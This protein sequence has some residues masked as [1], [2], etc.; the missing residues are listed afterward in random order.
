M[1][2]P[3][4]PTRRRREKAL[5][6]MDALAPFLSNHFHSKI[7]QLCVVNAVKNMPLPT[8]PPL[9]ASSWSQ[10]DFPA[11]AVVPFSTFG[12][13]SDGG[14]S[15]SN[16]SI[17]W[18]GLTLSRNKGFSSITGLDLARSWRFFGAKPF[19]KNS[20]LLPFYLMNNNKLNFL[21]VAVFLFI[22]II[23]D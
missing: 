19:K 11:F 5:W 16:F 15:E 13:V 3:L 1:L 23:R 17:N 21:N 6:M 18:R 12:P 9:L 10:F 4:R 7:P 22:S 2:E 20:F 14:E 8:T